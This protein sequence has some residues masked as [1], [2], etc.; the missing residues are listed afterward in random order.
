MDLFR[1]LIENQFSKEATKVLADLIEGSAP[2]PR[3]GGEATGVRGRGAGTG[4]AVQHG[5]EVL[6]G[7]GS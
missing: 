2:S 4:E 6:L 3:S 5:S 1:S 7:G